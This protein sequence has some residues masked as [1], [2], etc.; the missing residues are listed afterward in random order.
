MVCESG[1][2]GTGEGHRDGEWDRVVG[3]ALCRPG[4][5]WELP[6]G[7]E[8]R[9]NVG[10]DRHMDVLCS[11]LC[12]SCPV[13]AGTTVNTD[14]RSC[15]HWS[16]LV[17]TC[18][19]RPQERMGNSGWGQNRVEITDLLWENGTSLERP[20]GSDSG[21]LGRCGVWSRAEPAGPPPCAWHPQPG[22]APAPEC[23]LGYGHGPG[24]P[25]GCRP[26]CWPAVASW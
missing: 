17:I 25:E 19:V 18:V 8:S 3:L 4:R 16:G 10:R 6:A 23:A 12:S 26:G 7:G 2:P 15:W 5:V 9:G 11:S 20:S 14:S 21:A 13:G 24:W 22:P 1:S